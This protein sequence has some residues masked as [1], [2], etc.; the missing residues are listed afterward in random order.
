MLWEVE[1]RPGKGEIDR[2]AQRV[3]SEARALGAR[4]ITEV[5]AARSFLIEG[6]LAPDA[7]SS[8]IVHLLTDPVVESSTFRAIAG[9]GHAA[10]VT[11]GDQTSLLNV[12]F[13]PGVTDNVG[14]TAAQALRDLGLTVDRVA[15]CRKYWINST[16]TAPDVARL[17]GKVLAN[18]AIEHVIRGPLQFDSLAIGHAEPFSLVRVPLREL[19]D[20]ALL[21][22]S[23]EGQLSLS[24]AEMQTVQAHFRELGREPT[25]IEL[26]TIAQTWSEHC[27][28]K[29][30]AGRIRYRDENGERRFENML[31]ETIFAATQQL[32]KRFGKDDWCVSVFRDNA[33]VVTFNDE[34]DVCI[35]VETH[36]HPSAIEPY[37][38]ANTGLGGVIRDPLGT[39]LGAKPVCSTDVFCFAP[40]DTPYDALPPGVLHPR[41]VM[42]GVVAGVRD[43]GNRMGIPTVN[44]AVYFDERYIGNPLVYCGNVA[45]IPRGKS[46][47]QVT[48]GDLIVAVGGRTGRDGIHGAT[49][50][51]IELSHESES[52]SGGSVQIGNAITEKMLMDVVLAARDRGL[53]HAITDCGAGGFSSAVGE[54]GA[55]S[56]AEVWLEKAPL[57]YAGLSYTEIWISEA[58]ERM[59][60]AVPPE[61]WDAF[62]A[63]C[64]SEGVE[65]TAIG[66]Y[67]DTHQ[68]VLK[69]N[70][71]QVGELSMEFLHDG[72]P[73]VVREAV[74][75]SGTRRAESREAAEMARTL[76]IS[77]EDAVRN[78]RERQ[79][80]DQAKAQTYGFRSIDLDAIVIPN[81]VIGRL[82]EDVARELTII[83]IAAH[84][85]RISIACVDPLNFETVERVRLTLGCE[86][87]AS[88]ASAASIRGAIDRHY[89]SSSGETL[90]RILSS[91]NVCSKEWIIRQYDHEVQAGSVVK[92]LVGVAND[93]PSDAAVVQPD[94]ASR[95]GLV[96]GCGMNPRYGDIDPYWMAASAIDE[97]V[98]NC[99]AVGADP[100]RIAILDN[101]CWGNTARPET[102]GSLVRA[103]L[104]CQDVALA[105]GTPFVSGKD[106]L[107]NEFTYV[108][109]G[110]TK[111]ITIPPSLLITALG[112]IEQ[113]EQSVTMDLK[114]PGNL[115]F[116]V[117][118]TKA[119]LAGSHYSLVT[120]VDDD[121]WRM[122]RV[123]LE[124]APK[125]FGEVHAAIRQ[126]LIRSCHDLSEGGL[127]VALAEMAFAGGLGV[128][129]QLDVLSQSC[130]IKNP[131]V[132]LFSESNTR[133][134][135]EVAA[136]HV[137]KFVHTV[138]TAV[139]IG[140]VVSG[141]R[142][143]V[144][145]QD[146]RTVIDESLA[147]L[148]HVWQSPLKWE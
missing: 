77:F 80:V 148:K 12:L 94:L 31:K 78:V 119:D 81:E 70:G 132:M 28:H 50:S 5:A 138:P 30:L 6:N 35:K 10:A 144:R 9:A 55:D 45:L 29:T 47:K 72:R 11:P 99:V 51:S 135:V 48:S 130:W 52:I 33:G 128:E 91:L 108:A 127:A 23:K 114:A 42:K 26:E 101:F 84:E 57:K 4:S 120:G 140:S 68:L 145:D 24:L 85:E 147:E 123:D 113:I 3:L 53:Y 95:R 16:A 139:R 79:M 69:Y 38:G 142:L 64:A 118:E 21:K 65:A 2:E 17:C 61:N 110:E 103:A 86:V 41:A 98:R 136:E 74:W 92:P 112:Q 100:A 22:L 25:D 117:G 66:K 54:M 104:A 37:G 126:G 71:E 131:D 102:L 58:Q 87:E 109:D 13:K 124:R 36:N 43:Y 97:A 83:P 73:P 116:L 122:P 82:P 125:L 40:P 96:I 27:S 63:L 67:T 34:Y 129:A 105:Y 146:E 20:T 93:G 19:D 76:G 107:N 44:G 15:T 90:K 133:F 121:S 32:R 59:I 46:E 143:V 56:G 89:G 62:H 1:T 111:T 18:D 7:D 8:K 14:Q 60:L 134:V 115:L 49:F 106:S 75:E 141:D 39:G 88:M 137:G